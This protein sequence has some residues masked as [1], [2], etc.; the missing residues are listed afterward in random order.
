MKN[1]VAR[2]YN[3]V[4]ISSSDGKYQTVC[5]YGGKIYGSSDYGSTFSQKYNNAFDY[6]WRSVSLSST[7]QYQIAGDDNYLYVSTDYGENWNQ[8]SGSVNSDGAN[9]LN[10]T[11]KSWRSV[12]IYL[13]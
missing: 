7:G 12:R 4:S 6:N 3:S 2:N 5:V 10:A 11:L 8:S 9:S 1:G 13:C